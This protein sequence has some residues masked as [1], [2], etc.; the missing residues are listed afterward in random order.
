MQHEN[1][2]MWPSVRPKPCSMPQ[3][4]GDQMTLYPSLIPG[5]PSIYLAS[6][7]DAIDA[8][9][10]SLSLLSSAPIMQTYLLWLCEAASRIWPEALSVHSDV[11]FAAERPACHP[12]KQ[13]SHK[14]LAQQ[15]AR[16]LTKRTKLVHTS[17]SAVP[18]LDSA[19]SRRD[20]GS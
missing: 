5:Q 6:H 15:T 3:T 18:L 2:N 1:A 9:R 16:P 11:G 10:C 17:P 20:T 7:V 4:C 13:P 14:H 8:K 12:R 19:S